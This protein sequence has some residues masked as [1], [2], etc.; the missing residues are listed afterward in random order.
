M[1]L[2]SFLLFAGSAV[3]YGCAR[4]LSQRLKELFAFLQRPEIRIETFDEV[5]WGVTYGR[6][7][8]S[9]SWVV[10]AVSCLLLGG[11]GLGSLG[12]GLVVLAQPLMLFPAMMCGYAAWV[13]WVAF[14]CQVG[15]RPLVRRLRLTQ[16]HLALDDVSLGLSFDADALES[17]PSFGGAR[18]IRWG[19]VSRVSRDDRNHLIIGVRGAAD[20]VFGPLTDEVAADLTE[21][22]QRRSA[23]EEESGEVIDL[24]R[25]RLRALTERATRSPK[26][27]PES[28]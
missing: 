28:D 6:L 14:K 8:E 15:R 5:I 21:R 18:T 13:G 1:N 19:E 26:R 2:A 22:I 3:L 25:V 17:A 10:M 16:A 27:T 7:P 9:T 20:A 4:A 23:V 12:P 11:L 24:A